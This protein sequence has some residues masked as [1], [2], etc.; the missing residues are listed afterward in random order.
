M[1]RVGITAR[2]GAQTR[3]R[4]ELT[5]NRAVAFLDHCHRQASG[6]GWKCLRVSLGLKDRRSTAW[7]SHCTV[8]AP[9][10][11]KRGRHSRQ[12][13]LQ[14][15]RSARLRRSRVLTRQAVGLGQQ[16]WRLM[17]TRLAIFSTAPL[18]TRTSMAKRGGKSISAQFI[19]LIASTYGTAPTAALIV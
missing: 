13:Q 2:T 3:S 4:G 12:S 16:C 5:D 17:A 19:R 9:F 18:P 6:C 10:G 7:R 8:A 1:H 15:S 11:M 14:T